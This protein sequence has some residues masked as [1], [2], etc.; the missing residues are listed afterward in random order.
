MAL[1]TVRIQDK[2]VQNIVLRRTAQYIPSLSTGVLLSLS[3]MAIFHAYVVI[4]IFIYL[5]FRLNTD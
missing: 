5:D 2:Y 1:P 4:F 3:S